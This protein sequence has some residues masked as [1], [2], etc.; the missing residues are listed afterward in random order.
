MPRIAQRP[1]YS[2]LFGVYYAHRGLHDNQTDAPENSMKAFRKA[3]DCG[4][5]IELDVQL[6]RDRIPVVFHDESLKRVCGVSGNVRDYTYAELQK[7]NLCNST[8]HIP[9]F[10]D[11][12][13]LV[14]G[15]VPLIVE[16]KS[17]E[18]VDPLCNII[19]NYLLDYKGAYCVESFDPRVVKWYKDHRPEVIRG[20]LSTDFTTPEKHEKFYEKWVHY[21][22]TNCICR[23]DF[24]A[25]DHQH[26]NNI[27]RLLCKNLF[28][29]LGVTWTVK[30]Q[31]ELDNC[32]K[33]F[34]LFIFEG[35]IPRKP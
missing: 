22:L 13:Q 25:Y 5:G 6:T 34:S 28:G 14:N 4:Y 9:L 3:V 32:K 17:H 31:E 30:S 1:D 23:P 10:I 27:S 2:G 15:K 33:D 24:I 16:I 19:D 29:A 18:P 7:L 8:E 26:K 12:L 20:Q 21:L 35:F 11:F